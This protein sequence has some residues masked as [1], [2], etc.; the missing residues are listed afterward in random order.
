MEVKG[1]LGVLI[2]VA[3]VYAVLQIA[4]SSASNLRKAI[5]IA[6]VILLPVVGLIAWYLVGPGGLSR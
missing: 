2:L 5:W 3:D 4:Q 1:F 6:V